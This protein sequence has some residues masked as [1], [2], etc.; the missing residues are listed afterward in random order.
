MPL[1]AKDLSGLPPAMI[2]LGGCD[3][4][5]DEGREYA[6]RLRADGVNGMWLRSVL[7]T[8]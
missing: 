5:R 4:L 6:R 8:N 2:V 7:A 3:M 1:S